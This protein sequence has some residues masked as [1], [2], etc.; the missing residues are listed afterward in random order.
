MSEQEPLAQFTVRIIS[1]NNGSW[2]GVVETE[3][4]AFYFESE[5]QLVGWL[6]RRY[7]ALRSN[8]P[9]FTD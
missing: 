5:L 8:P 3:D 4:I 7:P 2:Q 6:L 1:A 9:K